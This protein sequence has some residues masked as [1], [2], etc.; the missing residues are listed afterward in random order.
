MAEPILR[1]EQTGDHDA[2]YQLTQRAFAPMAFA[3]G[4]EQDLI[5]ALRDADALTLSLVAVR[6]NEVVGHIAF[7]PASSADGAPGWYALGPV[8]V[9]PEVQGLGIGRLLIEAGLQRLMDLDAAGCILTGNPAYYRRFGFVVRADLAPPGEPA[10]YY[11]V[12][13]LGDP[14]P[15]QV[16]SFHPLF[17]AGET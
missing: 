2:I 12:R 11:M 13:P 3:A 17:H 6:E 9:A 10:E 7:S 14:S 1:D 15:A 4:D 16:V 8:S 5:N